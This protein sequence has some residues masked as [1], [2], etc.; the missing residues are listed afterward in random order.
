M[1]SFHAHKDHINRNGKHAA[2]SMEKRT[3]M[4]FQNTNN[5][6]WADQCLSDQH[7]QLEYILARKNGSTTCMLRIP[8]PRIF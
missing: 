6:L 4:P 7:D 5:K 2:D 1:P 8:E 3:L